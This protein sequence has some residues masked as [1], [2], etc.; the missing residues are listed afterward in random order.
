MSRAAKVVW[1]WAIALSVAL[2]TAAPASAAQPAGC[3]V[4][5]PTISQS[6][7]GQLV[8][9]GTAFCDSR[10]LRTFGTLIFQDISFSPDPMVAKG[11]VRV[12]ANNYQKTVQSCYNV[13]T[14]YFYSQASFTGYDYSE[15]GRRQF[16]AC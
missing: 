3:T 7:T 8:G 10:T 16:T 5:T 2:L 9:K 6:A 13:K 11:D 4:N 12:S 1:L 15:S 14:G